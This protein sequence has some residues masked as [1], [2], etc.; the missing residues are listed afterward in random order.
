MEHS[1]RPVDADADRCAP[2]TPARASRLIPLDRPVPREPPVYDH[3]RGHTPAG[4]R[5]ELYAL[6]DNLFIAA[7]VVVSLWLALLYLVEG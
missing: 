5:F 6:L 3:P 7:G 2:M 4:P 1:D